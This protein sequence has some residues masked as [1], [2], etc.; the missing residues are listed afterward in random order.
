MLGVWIGFASLIGQCGVVGERSLVEPDS[1]CQS[2][3]RPGPERTRCYI[4]EKSTKSV[5]P[6]LTN[7][8]RPILYFQL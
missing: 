3:V 7:F 2:V 5:F 4:T 6:F 8:N 1:D